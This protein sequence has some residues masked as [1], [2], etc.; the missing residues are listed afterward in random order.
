MLALKK[1]LQL[2]GMVFSISPALGKKQTV[3]SNVQTY[4]SSFFFVF[5]SSIDFLGWIFLYFF[6]STNFIIVKFWVAH[7]N[8]SHFIFRFAGTNDMAMC[9]AIG[10]LFTGETRKNL[11]EEV[12]FISL[13]LHFVYFC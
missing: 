9:F 6:R 11:I 12:V 2:D 8:F 1:L 5:H 10:I 3:T 7:Y 4:D 13:D